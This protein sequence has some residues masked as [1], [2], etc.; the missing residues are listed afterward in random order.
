[1]AWRASVLHGLD[2]RGEY[3]RM[4]AAMHPNPVDD[5]ADVEPVCLRQMGNG[6]PPKRIP[7][8]FGHRAPCLAIH[9]QLKAASHGLRPIPSQEAGSSRDVVEPGLGIPTV[10]RFK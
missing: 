2:N 5:L 1:M 10:L 9:Q 7:P 6:A 4:L 3:R 8:L